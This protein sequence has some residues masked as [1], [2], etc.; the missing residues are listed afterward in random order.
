MI[1]V[2]AR[3]KV[4]TE[5]LEQAW[6]LGKQ[7]VARSRQEPGCVSHAVY[8][9]DEHANHLVFVEEWESE[10]ALKTHFEVPASRDFVTALA[11]LSVGKTTFRI[12]GATELP[13]PQLARR[14]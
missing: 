12:Y 6:A 9:D 1:I 3:V 2:M 7:H 5:H 14:A 13:F 4:R 11:E 10:A 8:R